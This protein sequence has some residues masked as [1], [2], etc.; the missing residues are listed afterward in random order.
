[1]VHVDHVV[2]SQSDPG[3]LR[4]RA[5]RQRVLDAA[6]QQRDRLP[7]HGYRHHCRWAGHHVPAH[8]AACPSPPARRSPELGPLPSLSPPNRG[9]YPVLR[10]R[11][12]AADLRPAHRA[13]RHL[14]ALQPALRHLDAEGIPGGNPARGRGGRPGGRRQ[15]LDRVLT[16]VAAPGRTGHHGRRHHRVHLRL[17]RVPVCPDPDRHSKRPDL[18]RRCAGTGDPVR[19]H[20]ESDGSRR[21][22]RH[23]GAIGTHGGGPEVHG[24]RPDLR[25]HPREVTAAVYLNGAT[26]MTT[27]TQRVLEIARDTG[28][29]G[30]EA[31]AERLLS[32]SG[33]VRATAEVARPTDVLTLNGVA[34]TV[35]ADGRMDRQRLE[36]DLGPRLRICG[37]LGSPYLLAIPPRARGLAT[38]NAIPGTRGALE[39]ARD[40]A[41]AM[42]IQIAFEFLGFADCPINTPAIAAE[43]VDGIDG[44][45]LVLDSC[46][47]HASG[48]QPLDSFPADRLVLVHL[49]DAPDKP[50]REIED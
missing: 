14:L 6:P 17:E 27:P 39:L 3:V 18:P 15:S 37:D 35:R 26:L 30:I 40:R 29:A 36:T 9:R 28:Y 19:H 49:N 16:S 41:D 5:D 10:H 48:S 22:D 46:H 34:L 4:Q 42:G 50:P 13:D 43:A 47:W 11:P 12:H 7:V 33:E 20:L 45:H 32:D 31:R 8:P 44:I 25:R 23:V 21:R 2:S 1:A 38:G 24:G